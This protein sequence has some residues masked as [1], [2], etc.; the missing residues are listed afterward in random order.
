VTCADC[1]LPRKKRQAI[2]I[3]GTNHGIFGFHTVKNFIDSGVCGCIL[4][5]F[6][7]G[8][9]FDSPFHSP[10]LIRTKNIWIS[11]GVAAP[12]TAPIKRNP[13]Q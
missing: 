7:H 6:D 11:M 3:S 2:Y 9:A 4:G 13:S 12:A 1:F 5:F 8:V 10:S